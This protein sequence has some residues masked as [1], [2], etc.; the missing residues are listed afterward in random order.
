MIDKEFIEY[1]EKQYFRTNVDTG[2]N[3]NAMFIWN[4][5]RQHTGLRPLSIS[6]LPR[7][8]MTHKRYHTLFSEYGCIGKDE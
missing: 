4:L 7:Y 1:V 6:D 3:D 2:A 5:V 8:C